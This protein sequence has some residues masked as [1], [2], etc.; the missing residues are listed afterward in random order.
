L[1][2]NVGLKKKLKKY[3]YKRVYLGLFPDK[4]KN[5][6][7]K[8]PIYQKS[9]EFGMETITLYKKFF[10][11][12]EYVISKQLLRSGTGLGANINE[13][14]SA[15]SLKDFISKNSI[16]LKEAKESLYWLNLLNRSKLIEYDYQK[17]I[18]LNVEIIKIISKILVTSKKKL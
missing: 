10:V 9:S 8:G 18:D 5:N 6:N 4:H 12:R 13:A 3:F 7:M 2:V 11:H 16:A 17:L 15:E 14:S 1:S